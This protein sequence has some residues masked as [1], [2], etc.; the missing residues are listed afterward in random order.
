MLPAPAPAVFKWSKTK[1][2]L[3]YRDH[4][5]HE[6]F[7]DWV[8][9]LIGVRKMNYY[10]IVSEVADVND[11]YP[12][13]HFLVAFDAAPNWVNPGK[14]DYLGVHPNVKPVV[15]AFHWDNTWAYHTKAPVLLTQSDPMEKSED[16]HASYIDFVT[17]FKGNYFQLQITPGP[18]GVYI[19]RNRHLTETIWRNR[20]KAISLVVF[21]PRPWQ[22]QVMDYLAGPPDPRQILFVVDPIGNQGKSFF[23]KHLLDTTDC[24]VL[25]GL[26]SDAQYLYNSERVVLIDLPRSDMAPDYGFLEQLK[27]GF[28]VSPKYETRLKRFAVPHVVVFSNHLPD[29]KKL[30][31]DRYLVFDMDDVPLDE[32]DFA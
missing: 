20:P 22:A 3:T 24:I 23:T 14:F 16:F 25:E 13:T 8:R 30:S 4:V 26:R 12:H 5:D 31:V 17:T 2:H 1:Y 18:M 27:N 6:V 11:P 19:T 29:F 15:S 9:N 21:I 7:L 10:S 32:D 28:F